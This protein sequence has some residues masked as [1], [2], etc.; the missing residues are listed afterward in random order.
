[1]ANRLQVENLTKRYGNFTALN[2]V[3][4]T[5]EQ[6]VTG[7]LG[8]NGAGKSTLMKLLTDQMRRTDGRILYNGTEILDMGAKWRS[9]IGYTPQLQGLYEDSSARQFLYYIASLKGIRRKA[10]KEQTA[11]LLKL[12]NLEQVAH[13]KIG[14]FSGGMRQRVLLAAAL[15]GEPQVLILDEPT[16]GLDPEERIRLR[17]YITEIARERI[18][19]YA[20]H[21]VSD[22]ECV[23]KRVMLLD[24][25]TLISC[26]TPE[27]LIAA[28][29]GKIGTFSGSYEEILALQAQYPKGEIKQTGTGFSLRIAARHLPENC[30]VADDLGLEDVY[31]LLLEDRHG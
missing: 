25:G 19:L 6:G 7:L 11:M 1:M 8:A 3:T 28:A 18:V 22:I 16:A 12:V 29:H 27:A 23:A 9:V 31:R 10:A 5:L 4:I 14:T 21:V 24:H 13:K 30:T 15:L 17:N 20:T 2:G 26:D